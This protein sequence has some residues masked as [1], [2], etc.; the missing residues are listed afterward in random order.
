MKYSK[1]IVALLAS[2]SLAA[3]LA[4]LQ[5]DAVAACE[6][7]KDATDRLLEAV[8]IGDNAETVCLL[9][10]DCPRI[11]DSS[12]VR[13]LLT[14]MIANDRTASFMALLPRVDFDCRSMTTLLLKAI[15]LYRPEIAEYLVSEGISIDLAF[16]RFW[17]HPFEINAVKSFAALH[18]EHVAEMVPDFDRHPPIYRE[19]FDFIAHCRAISPEFAANSKYHP[20]G[21]LQFALDNLGFGDERLAGVI[22]EL[23]ASGAVVEEAAVDEFKERN[24]GLVQ[25]YE[26]LLAGLHREPAAVVIKPVEL[27]EKVMILSQQAYVKMDSISKAGDTPKK[28]AR[29]LKK[30]YSHFEYD[31]KVLDLLAI[32][33]V[34]KRFASVKYMFSHTRIEEG[35]VG[36][37]MT[38]LLCTAVDWHA[39]RSL[40]YLLAQDPHRKGRIEDIWKAAAPAWTREEVEGLARSHPDRIE[41]LAPSSEILRTTKDAK[42]LSDMCGF[43]AFGATISEA[44]GKDEAYLR[45]VLESVRD[46]PQM[47]AAKKTEALRR[48]PLSEETDAMIKKIMEKT[49]LAA[50]GSQGGA[51]VSMEEAVA[52]RRK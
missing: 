19:T 14:H 34:R 10:R 32:M 3:P 5:G 42:R 26:A 41:E 15:E 20:S 37:A 35:D 24:A 17:E 39:P 33:I 11:K 2:A 44:F 50:L 46:N 7:R 31:E 27:E 43:V 47:G 40:D 45:M 25:S 16:R 21:L 48:L 30:G 18:P 49:D 12:S 13:S 52:L 8:E 29:Y 22:R 51:A 1:I 23:L 9:L 28:L 38:V 36:D 6:L 4:R